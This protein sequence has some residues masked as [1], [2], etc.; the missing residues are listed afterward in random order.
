MN[1]PTYLWTLFLAFQGV[2]FGL[3][4]FFQI[5]GAPDDLW[6]IALAHIPVCMVTAG[7]ESTLNMT[8]HIPRITNHGE[9]DDFFNPLEEQPH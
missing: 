4:W 7:L 9:L 6:L 3:C 1:R 5:S 2:V 8:S